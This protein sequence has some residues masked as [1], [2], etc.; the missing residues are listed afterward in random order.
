MEEKKKSA[1]EKENNAQEEL[2][3]YKIEVSK[4]SN[5]IQAVK[6]QNLFYQQEMKTLN[7]NQEE[8]SGI[9]K[10]TNMKIYELE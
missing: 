5:E 9:K 8:L 7:L 10:Q 2:E 3:H 1:E 6:N 4:L